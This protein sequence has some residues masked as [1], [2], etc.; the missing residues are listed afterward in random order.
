M[1]VSSSFEQASQSLSS[2]IYA[3]IDLKIRAANLCIEGVSLAIRYRAEI[4]GDDAE[5]VGTYIATALADASLLVESAEAI[6]IF[7][8]HFD[9]GADRKQS[10]QSYHGELLNC[11]VLVQEN[12][13]QA[14]SIAETNVVPDYYTTMMPPVPN[15]GEAIKANGDLLA[16][17][18]QMIFQS[19]AE[20]QDLSALWPERADVA[21][22]K[23]AHLKDQPRLE[24]LAANLTA[25]ALALA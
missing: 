18:C 24:Q 14:I 19:H 9:L 3:E 22:F 11:A 21:L 17:T 15:P 25:R 16:E 13:K 1:S 7:G 23:D 6:L 10:G 20:L 12:V 4:F 8:G 2:C 5:K